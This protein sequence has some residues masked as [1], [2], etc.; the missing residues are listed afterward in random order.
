MAFRWYVV[1]VYSGF[2][3]KVMEAIYEQAEKKGM[4][5]RFEQILIPSEEVNEVR[6]GQKVTVDRKYFPGYILIKMDLDDDTWNLVRDTQRVSSFLGPRGKPMPISDA[7][8]TRILKQAQ[9]SSEKL[10][11]LTT[12]FDIGESVRII[13]GPF[14]S[15]S[16]EVSD[17][18][19]EKGRVKVSV[20]IFG[21]PTPV[22]LE[23]NQVDRV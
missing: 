12:G 2:E 7:E 18:D 21:R 15:F 1:N 22:E 6:R 3:N 20:M 8:I 11:R 5:D 9:D 19:Q 13:D 4:R 17:V 14:T 16:G 10:V 23:F